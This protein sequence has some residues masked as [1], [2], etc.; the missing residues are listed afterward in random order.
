MP[1]EMERE[2]PTEML[3]ETQQGTRQET[4]QEKLHGTPQEMQT[5]RIETKAA[6]TI[7]IMK[8]IEIELYS[9]DLIEMYF[10]LSNF[11]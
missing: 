1:Q 3:P 9:P 5:E 4:H 8:T 11:H 6:K 10:D 7:T 2:T